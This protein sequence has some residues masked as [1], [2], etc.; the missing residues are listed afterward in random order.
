MTQD[1]RERH[2]LVVTART[3]FVE[4]WKKTQKDKN[5]NERKWDE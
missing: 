5:R 2:R 1:K 3:H 4:K